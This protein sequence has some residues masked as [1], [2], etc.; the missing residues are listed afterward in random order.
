MAT[1]R[2]VLDD[3]D[4]ATAALTLSLLLQDVYELVSNFQDND[5]SSKASDEEDAFRRYQSDLE[6]EIR[7]YQPTAHRFPREV[8]A[9]MSLA[10]SGPPQPPAR[11]LPFPA[12]HVAP[13]SG[14][15]ASTV[16]PIETLSAKDSES[17]TPPPVSESISDA[18][19]SNL[20]Q[21]TVSPVTVRL[22]I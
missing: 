21:N 6:S 7:E 4:A 15:A 1:Q 14:V 5:S 20:K 10:M 3:M 12:V 13:I 2:G 8:Q 9:A 18:K 11:P 22:P 17:G 19:V 16:V